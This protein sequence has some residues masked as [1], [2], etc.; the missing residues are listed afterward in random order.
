MSVI[1]AGH[2]YTSRDLIPTRRFSTW[3]ILPT[4]CLPARTFKSRISCDNES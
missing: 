4:P 1:A 2:S 3:S